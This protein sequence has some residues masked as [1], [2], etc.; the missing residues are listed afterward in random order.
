MASYRAPRIAGRITKLLFTLF[1]FSICGILVWRVFF[2]TKIPKS[3]DALTPNTALSQAYAENGGELTFQYQELSSITRARDSYGYFSAVTCIFIPE[4]DQVQLVFRYNNSTIRHLQQDYG[5]AELPQKSDHL[6]DV[7]LVVAN[8][9]TPDVH[10]DDY[11][12]ENLTTQRYFPSLEPLR[13]ET[14]LYTFYRYVFDGVT[15][16]DVTNSVY[17]D[18]YYVED[19]NYGER[20]YSSLLIYAWD[21]PWRT[22]R[23]SRAE[24]R[25][26][27]NLS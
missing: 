4:A 5:L 22:Y 24:L 13:E 27:E 6:F 10:D 1:I 11:V 15:V 21:E 8:D 25:S 16:E 3:I 26:I 23:P 2:S 20:P 17:M 9:P 19:I 7:T 18:V 12:G 14:S